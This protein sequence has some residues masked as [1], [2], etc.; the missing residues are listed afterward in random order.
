[1]K[2]QKKVNIQTQFFLTYIAIAIMIIF[3]FSVF[4][5]DYISKILI[6]R[7]TTNFENL[8]N[9]FMEQIDSA[10]HTMDDVSLN[11]SYSNL[12]LSKI[13][14]FLTSAEEGTNDFSQLVELFVALNG[15]DYRVAQIN[16]IGNSGRVITVGPYT[17]TSIID[18]NS[19]DWIKSNNMQ[20]SYKEISLPY[21]SSKMLNNSSVSL[22]YLSLYRKLHDSYGRQI[23]Y[24]ETVQTC[25]KVFKSILSYKNSTKDG[26]KIY[27][28]NQDGNL[29]YPYDPDVV[30]AENKDTY[31]H[32]Y[33]VGS[34]MNNSRI[35]E[36][37]ISNEKELVTALSSPYSGWTYVCAQ[38]ESIII[39]P[40][41]V[42]S[43]VLIWVVLLVTA[44][45]LLF[46]YL[47]S[48]SLTRPIHQLLRAFRKTKID[49]LGHVK[50]DS[51]QTSFNEFDELN[52]AF[53]QMSSELK[54]SM[55]SLIETR[56]QELKSRSL[57]L[58]SQINPH[59][60]YNSLSSITVLAEN[61][62][63][64]EVI[65]FSRNL[66]S[67][68]RYITH[69]NMQ[70]VTLSAELTYIQKYMYCMKVRYQSSLNY[71]IDVDDSLYNIEIPKLL[72]QPLVENALKYGINC[73]PPW[74]I[75]VKSEITKDYW[76]IHVSDSGPGFTEEALAQIGERF[77]R[78]DATIGMPET[79]IDGLGMLNVYQRWKLY[80]KENYI[81]EYS[82]QPEGGSRVSIGTY[83]GGNDE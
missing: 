12:V 75:Q 41:K 53:Y 23:G 79:K 59:F 55:D 72:I 6:Q 58:Q 15:V 7:E 8:A 60:Y 73:E 61:G 49:T 51:L 65:Q 32:Y 43:K 47:M 56:Q 54:T 24:I 16:V 13:N 67:M 26:M 30:S 14:H 20:K 3:L 74:E 22:S 57:A 10:L 71:V 50:R 69:G 45:V 68:M 63:T 48:K 27:V 46:S 70:I 80:C 37:P 17:N 81:F 52:D 38:E 25:K 29:I 34:S 76:L 36:N 21:Q 40:V 66:T 19:L 39:A 77:H 42:F 35:L 18:L 11:I 78:A 2:I 83:F 1:M 64:D 82:N 33:T 31:I 62:Q 9:S 5:Y 28:Y 4:F 44:F